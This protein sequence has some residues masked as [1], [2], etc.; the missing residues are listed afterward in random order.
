MP[1]RAL[2]KG[3]EALIPSQPEKAGSTLTEVPLQQVFPNQSQPRRSFD[4]EKLTELA[5]SIRQKG[6]LQP[7]LV[8]PVGEKYEIVAGERRWRAA[9]IAG[10]EQVPVIVG[11]YSDREVMELALIENLQ[12][13][14]LNP[15][16]EAEAFRRLIE[17]F[18]MTQEEVAKAVGKARATVANSLRL[19]SLARDVRD[20]VAEGKL[21]AGHAKVLASLSEG[22][23]REYAIRVLS[24][25]LSVRQLEELV[26]GKGKAEKHHRTTQKRLTVVT[27]PELRAVEE[28]LQTA[29]GTKVTIKPKD[30]EGRK[31]CIEVEFYSEEDLNRILEWFEE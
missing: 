14:D 4:Q 21:T 31:G 10:L 7:L 19:L 30:A 13:E 12:R 11:H 9:Q 3:L 6:M 16:E 29:L 23:Q 5:E 1:R 15:I 26:S 20:L 28:R 27:V 24:E 8:R 2:G 22:K 17:E 18:A 25:G